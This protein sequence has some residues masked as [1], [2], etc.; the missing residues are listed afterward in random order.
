[1]H[2]KSPQVDYP[3]D[4]PGAARCRQFPEHHSI[5]ISGRRGECIRGV[6]ILLIALTL[7]NPYNMGALLLKKASKL[8]AAT[9]AVFKKKEYL[10]RRS[11]G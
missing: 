9:L 11:P 10:C 1:M 5:V 4:F 2:I 8:F 6:I 3:V 7:E